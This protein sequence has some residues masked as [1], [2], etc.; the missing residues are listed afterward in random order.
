MPKKI[1]VRQCVACREH[2]E[3]PQL[4]RIVRTPEGAVVYDRRGK[5]PGRG[6]YICQCEACLEKAVKSRALERALET[7]ITGEV[8]DAL[9]AQMK[10]AEECRNPS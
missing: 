3:K 2:R 6:A 1:T 8:L 9:R 4:A 5:V 7:A 10:E